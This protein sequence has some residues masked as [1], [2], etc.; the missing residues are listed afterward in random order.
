MVYKFFDKN[1]TAEP[2]SLERSAKRVIGSSVKK[3]KDTTKPSSLERSSLKILIK[4]KY[5]HNLKIIC[6]EYN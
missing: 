3:L 1:A 2:S 6:W 4:E 5:I